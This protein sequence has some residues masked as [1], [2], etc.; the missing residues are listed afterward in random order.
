MRS[1]TR[2]K[3][4]ITPLSQEGFRDNPATGTHGGIEVKGEIRRD[5][6][7]N[8]AALRS[9][10]VEQRENETAEDSYERRLKLRR[11]IL[12]LALVSLTHHSD[13]MFNLREGCLLRV[14]TPITWEGVPFEEKSILSRLNPLSHTR[15]Q[16]KRRPPS[17][18][19]STIS[20]SYSTKG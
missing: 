15:M 14:A 5:A 10:G 8:L 6:I 9:L 7:I 19:S 20:H 16:L 13:Q 1:T 17:V 2:V 3:G 18:C 11:Y 12:G 4:T